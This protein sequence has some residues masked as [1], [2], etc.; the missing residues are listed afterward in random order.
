MSLA[1]IRRAPSRTVKKTPR[2]FTLTVRS[3]SSTES[4]SALPAGLTPAFAMTVST[5]PNERSAAS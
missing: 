3:K 5:T 4:P 1:T 2:R